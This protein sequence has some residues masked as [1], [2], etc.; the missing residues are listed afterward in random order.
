MNHVARVMQ[1]IFKLFD[2]TALRARE[3]K[4]NPNILNQGMPAINSLA[5]EARNLLIAYYSGCEKTYTEGLY[6][7]QSSPVA[8]AEFR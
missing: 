2:E 6:R 7:L 3:M 1:V 4:I 8:D 5:E